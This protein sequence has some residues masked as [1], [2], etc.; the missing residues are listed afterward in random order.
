M[1]IIIFILMNSITFRS[2]YRSEIVGQKCNSL[3]IPQADLKDTGLY[4]CIASNDF[5][6]ATVKFVV[7]INGESL[8]IHFIE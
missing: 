6:N 1:N 5:G 4:E 3:E 2:N 7:N 8:A